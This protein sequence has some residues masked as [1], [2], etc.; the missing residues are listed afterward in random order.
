MD[1]YK[2]IEMLEYAQTAYDPCS[3]GSVK[4][5]IDK[6]LEA[7]RKQIPQ[8]IVESGKY[9]FKCPCCNVIFGIEKEDILVF[10]MDPP[11]HCENCGQMLDWDWF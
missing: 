11:K 7:L 4:I 8:T 1:N 10:D 2:A 5:A 6:A 3:Y 9:G